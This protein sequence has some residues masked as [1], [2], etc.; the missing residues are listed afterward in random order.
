MVEDKREG[1]TPVLKSIDSSSNY[2]SIFK[3]TSLF[4]GVQIYQ[5]LIDIIRSKFIALLL[6]PTG[7]GIQG[8]YTSATQL[9]QHLTSFG[10][11]SSAVRNVAEAYGSGD[12]VRI[13]KVVFS[14]RRL[15]W[16]TGLLGVLVV[17]LFSPLLSKFSFGDS[18]HILAFVIISVTLLLAQ[19]SAGQ[20]VILQGTRRLKLLAKSTALGATLG[21][22]V[23][24][25]LYYWL[26]VRG[27][28]PNIVISAVTT[29]LLTWYYSGKVEVEKI[30]MTGKEVFQIGKT[31][32][33]MG[34]AMSLSHI[35]T[36]AS[37]YVLRA[38]IRAWDGVEAV[39][40]FTA[41]FLLMNQYTGLVFKAMGTDFYPRLAAVNN[42]NNNCRKIMNQQGEIGLLILGPLLV[43]CIVFIPLV[44]KLLYS[45][46]FLPIENYIIWCS[47]G[48]LFKMASWSVSYVFVAKGESR[49]FMIIES[50]AAVYTL[51]LNLFGYKLGGLTGIGISFTVSYIIY[52]IQVFVIACKKYDFSFERSFIITFIVHFILLSF[53][54]SCV[55][56]FSND[57]M[58]YALGAILTLLSSLYSYRELDRRI[59]L[60]ILIN[61][62]IKKNS[63]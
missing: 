43:V 53:C 50:T 6:G 29:L 19:L 36:F 39:G 47:L 22:V 45:E 26:G 28:I 11:S 34:I 5:I 16:I 57:L 31:M 48:M 12:K 4:G 59:G 1:S 24:V 51:L 38:C 44:V 30:S 60:K 55:V 27:I 23:S 32:L 52:L 37:S 40:F 18:D 14:L 58:K 63:K 15:V 42:D 9:I 49:L 56:L 2:R 41:G 17:I 13:S 21:L 62:K 3:A 54:V 10:L 35:L 8:L 61:N 25:P 33:I 46:D 7:V 20:K